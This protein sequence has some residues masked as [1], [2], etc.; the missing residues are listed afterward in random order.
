MKAIERIADSL[1]RQV[2]TNDESQFW[3]VSGRDRTDAIFVIRLLQEK[4]LTVGKQIFLDLENA[5]DQVP[6]KVI[7]WTMRKICVEVWIVNLVRGMNENVQSC[8][9][10]GGGLSDEFEVN[11]RALSSVHCSSSSC[12]MLCHGDWKFPA[13]WEQNSIVCLYQEKGDALDHGNYRGLKLTEQAMKVIERIA[14]SLIRQVV[15]TD[16]STLGG[17][18]CR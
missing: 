12:L 16:R 10:F 9:R 2:V 14:Y 8:I 4:Y 6:Q 3:F 18:L 5:F 7:W 1:I 17:P 11:T 15:T 13:D